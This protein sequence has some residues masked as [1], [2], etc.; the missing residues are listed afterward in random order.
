[1]RLTEVLETIGSLYR[2]NARTV[3]ALTAVVAIPAFVLSAIVARALAPIAERFA[4]LDPFGTATTAPSAAMLGD[5]GAAA[6]LSFAA[7]AIDQIA[8]A[9]I[10]AALAVALGHPGEPALSPGRALRG[11]PAVAL[12][13]VP[14]VAIILAALVGLVLAWI[15]LQVPLTVAL[16]ATPVGGGP[17]AFLVLLG[18]VAVAAAAV[19]LLVRWSLA[20]PVAAL[21]RSNPVATLGR[22]W[23]LVGGSTWR[24]LGYALLVG[25]V[26]VILD[27]TLVQSVAAIVSAVV[28]SAVTAVEVG[29]G[30]VAQV[31]LAP[32]G[33]LLSLVL[34][35]DLRLRAPGTQ[36]GL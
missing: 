31:L 16:G 9:L 25:V 14:A 22:S 11:L 15:V 24:V 13:L 35:H 18:V 6:A 34:Y 19:F 28:P 5:L 10:A 8:I 7:I 20:A 32:I 12:R 2:A 23:S 29:L 27:L 30:A 1:M 4:A 21:E 33:A 17:G 36:R 26:V 3:I